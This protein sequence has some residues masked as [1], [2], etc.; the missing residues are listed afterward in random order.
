MSQAELFSHAPTKASS[1]IGSKVVNPLG[2]SVGAIKEMVIDPR[3]GRV[4]YVVV[5]FGGVFGVGEKLFAIPFRAFD[6]NVSKGEYVLKVTKEQ[7]EKAPGFDSAHWPSLAD[8]KW[9]RAIHTY[10]NHA[11]YWE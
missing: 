8:E 6:Y 11:P 3:S 7:V 5:A 2:D 1:I 9:N 4:A 10:Y